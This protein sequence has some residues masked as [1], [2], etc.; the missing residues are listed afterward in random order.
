MRV[1]GRLTF[2]AGLGLTGPLGC[3]ARPPVDLAQYPP[4]THR[5]YALMEQRCTRCHE[6]DRP[7]QANVGQG[8]WPAYVR[9]MAKHPAAG[10]SVAEQREIVKFLEAHA[11]LRALPVTDEVP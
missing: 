8:G 9:R 6:L 10:I 3:G 1:L 11:A 7:L 4:A 5:G 2:W